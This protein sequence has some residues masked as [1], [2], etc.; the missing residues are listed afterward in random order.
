MI[1]VEGIGAPVPEPSAPGAH[2]LNSQTRDPWTCESET[3]NP[4]P[5][6]CERGLGVVNGARLRES[7]E[8]G[9]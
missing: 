3:L 6:T 5:E 8:E 1:S 7:S 4:K 9:S 2:N